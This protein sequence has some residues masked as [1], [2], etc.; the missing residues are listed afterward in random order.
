[1]DTWEVVSYEAATTSIGRVVGW[2]KL[3]HRPLRATAPK[4]WSPPGNLVVGGGGDCMEQS[5]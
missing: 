1:M 3:G 5:A 2:A 4:R